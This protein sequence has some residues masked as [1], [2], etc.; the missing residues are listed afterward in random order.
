MSNEL[1]FRITALEEALAAGLEDLL[2]L[3][4]EEVAQDHRDAPLAPDW[5]KY[6]HL[7]RAGVLTVFGAWR[8]VRLVGYNVFFVQPTLHHANTLWAL[9]DLLYL[10]PEERLGSAGIRLVSFAETELAK[11]GV[12]KVLYQP[13]IIAHFGRGKARGTVGDLLAK[14]GYR[15]VE[16]VYAKGL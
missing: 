7:A 13:N 16:N 6:R 11:R 2:V 3:H 8:G 4:W 1:V 5:P 10:E 12:K 9:N 15:H 14:L